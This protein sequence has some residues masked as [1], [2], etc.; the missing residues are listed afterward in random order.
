M[1]MGRGPEQQQDPCNEDPEPGTWNLV[2]GGGG[3]ALIVTIKA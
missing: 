3:S 2:S 1:G